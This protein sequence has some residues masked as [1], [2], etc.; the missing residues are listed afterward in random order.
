MCLPNSTVNPSKCQEKSKRAQ[1][2]STEETSPRKEV[3]VKIEGLIW[4][5]QRECLPEASSKVCS[6][7]LKRHI[8]QELNLSLVWSVRGP[9]Q[10]AI[11]LHVSQKIMWWLKCVSLHT[12]T[13]HSWKLFPFYIG[14][15]GNDCT[16]GYICLYSGSSDGCGQSVQTFWNI[17]KL[18]FEILIR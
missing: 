16:T 10:A 18:P 3:L 13:I 9:G 4:T 2:Q 12:I 11:G 5:L 8:H 6:Q 1:K 17:I 14:S 15:Q 7:Q